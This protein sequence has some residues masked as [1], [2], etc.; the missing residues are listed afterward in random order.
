[1]SKQFSEASR[2]QIPAILHLTRL[3]YTYLPDVVNY[4]HRTNILTDIFSER[5]KHFNP[6]ISDNEIRL[7]IDNL[8][9]IANNDDLGREFYTKINE[10]S[11]IK[12]IDFE[13]PENNLWH[14]TAGTHFDAAQ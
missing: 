3:G 14:C 9:R 1:M 12:L 7:L 11:G 4:D 2:V 10:T 8:A 6:T 13:N 5:V